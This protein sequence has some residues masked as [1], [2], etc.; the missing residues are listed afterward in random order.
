MTAKLRIRDSVVVDMNSYSQDHISKIST[1]EAICYI[2]K[3]DKATYPLLLHPPVFV[4][5]QTLTCLSHIDF[6]VIISSPAG[7]SV[8][9]IWN[10]D[11]LEFTIYLLPA[12]LIAGL[13]VVTD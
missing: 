12:T 7:D 11:I 2:T 3:K 8:A 13:V 9:V 10:S 5:T 1:N 6:I 4:L